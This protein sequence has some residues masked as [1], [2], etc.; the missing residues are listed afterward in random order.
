MDHVRQHRGLLHAD[1]PAG[2][3]HGAR[4]GREER[5]GQGERLVVAGRRQVA[6]AG[7][8][9][10]EAARGPG[11]AP[12]GPPQ[13]LLHRQDRAARQLQAGPPGPCAADVGVT[14]QV[15]HRRARP[16]GRRQRGQYLLRGSR[17]VRA[18]RAEVAGGRVETVPDRRRFRVPCFAGGCSRVGH[19]H[20]AVA[21]RERRAA[22]GLEQL[23]GRWRV[24]EDRLLQRVPPR[25][26]GP[27]AVPG[28]VPGQQ[29]EPPARDQHD[30]G[31]GGRG[32]AAARGVAGDGPEHRGGDRG[33]GPLA[34]RG[35]RVAP[36]GEVVRAGAGEQ[37][38]VRREVVP[39]RGGAPVEQR[40][41]HVPRGAGRGHD[42]RPGPAPVGGRQQVGEGAGAGTAQRLPDRREAGRRQQAGQ[43]GSGER[44]Q[45]PL[46][47]VVRHVGGRARQQ[48]EQVAAAAP[49]GP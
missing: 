2:G 30:P 46:P 33:P 18:A 23:P 20:R 9:V 42:Q 32:A 11:R 36:P 14:G 25:P 16:G 29:A 31:R 22:A 13:D 48:P 10:D 8:Q 37:R 34:R 47:Q 1:L 38:V 43:R 28:G 5:G 45:R 21:H 26:A 44:R 40:Q 41:R 24:G 39:Q 35:Q 4:A 27:L 6:A 12:G 3:Q 7:H 17:P 15:Q 49:R 19:D